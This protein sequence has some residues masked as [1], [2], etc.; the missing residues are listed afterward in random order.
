MHIFLD[1]DGPVLDVTRR[2]YLIYSDLLERAGYQPFD[3][4]SYWSLKCLSV[5]EAAIVQRAL[6]AEKIQTYLNQRSQMLEDPACLVHDRLQTGVFGVLERWQ[7]Q[8]S[9]HLV[10]LRRNRDALMSQLK[11]LGISAFFKSIHC[12]DE[13]DANWQAKCEWIRASGADPDDALII[14]DTEVDILAGRAAGIRT[15]AVSCGIRN[16]RLLNKLMPDA[17]VSSLDQVNDNILH[18]LP[19]Q[20][21]G[22]RI[23]A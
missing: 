20:E 18:D 7:Y 10:T 22:E 4:K 12:A 9:L 14:G 11:L 2:Y 6:P 17:I 3:Q 21:R 1:L 5:N 8:H 16:C 15:V 19:A 13:G 23:S